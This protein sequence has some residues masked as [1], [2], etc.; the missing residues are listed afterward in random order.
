MTHAAVTITPSEA[1][2]IAAA[3]GAIGWSVAGRYQHRSTKSS[4]RVEQKLDELKDAL[5]AHVSDYQRH[6]T[7]PAPAPRRRWLPAFATLFIRMFL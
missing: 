2:I 7:A 6:Q 5:T 1:S 3:I 4:E